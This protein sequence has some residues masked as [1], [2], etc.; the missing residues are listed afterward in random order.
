MKKGYIIGL[1]LI[2]LFLLS[3]FVLSNESV[4]RTFDKPIIETPSIF[5]KSIHEIKYDLLGDSK[6]KTQ[7]EVIDENIILPEYLM[8]WFSR[9]EFDRYADFRSDAAIRGGYG[10]NELC[11]TEIE[12][13]VLPDVTDHPYYQQFNNNEEEE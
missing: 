12:L 10:W 8:M 1:I 9:T 5:G 7:V 3:S 4:N 6:G 2:C 11:E 13:P